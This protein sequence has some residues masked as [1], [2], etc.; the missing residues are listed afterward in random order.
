[1]GRRLR[2]AASVALAFTRDG[3]DFVVLFR[4]HFH[5]LHPSSLHHRRY[6]HT[7]R[8]HVD[9]PQRTEHEQ[10]RQSSRPDAPDL[11]FVSRG[12]GR[13]REIEHEAGDANHQAA[14]SPRPR[15]RPFASVKF[16]LSLGTWPSE[17]S[18]PKLAIHFRSTSFGALSRTNTT[19]VAG[20]PRTNRAPGSCAGSSRRLR[21]T[22]IAW[23]QTPESRRVLPERHDQPD[24]ARTQKVSA[25][26]RKKTFNENRQRRP[27][28]RFVCSRYCSVPYNVE[29]RQE[30]RNA[31][32]RS[33]Q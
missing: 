3:P 21:A 26:L 8:A 12:F 25:S 14:Q 22:R 19:N 9:V 33:R 24:T 27:D 31:G 32:A 13:I 5:R 7:E 16:L 6:S 23:F 29:R 15:T 18:P 2:V 20:T 30:R 1:M 10:H 28:W 4:P 17:K 11:R